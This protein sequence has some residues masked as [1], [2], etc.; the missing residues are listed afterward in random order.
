MATDSVIDV[1]RRALLERFKWSSGHADVWRVFNDGPSLAAVVDGLVEPWRSSGITAV[2][3]IEARGFLLGGAV[4][5]KLG[6][7]FHAVRKTDGMLPGPKRSIRTEPDY[8]GL[9]YTLRMQAVLKPDE[10]VLLVD[11]WAE[12]GSQALGVCSLVEQSGATFAGV[13]VMVDQLDDATRS[14][15]AR[16]T[17]L[18]TASELGD[19]A[20]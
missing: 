8:R 7:G 19:S 13:S 12:R 2:T 3:G 16:V 9:T 15:L 17:A 18:V 6:V 20:L 5:A 11:D 10:R 14:R 4:A 1:A